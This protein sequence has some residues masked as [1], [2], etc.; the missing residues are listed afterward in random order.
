MR[1]R[2]ARPPNIADPPT[3]ESQP[4]AGIARAGPAG[5]V[6]KAVEVVGPNES[7]VIKLALPKMAAEIDVESEYPVE[8][9]LGFAACPVVKVGVYVPPLVE[10]GEV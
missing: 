6:I 10:L 8:L 2:I 5:V 4:V 1:R 3:S 7:Y 9:M